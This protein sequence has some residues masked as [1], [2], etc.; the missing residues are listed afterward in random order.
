[1]SINVITLEGNNKTPF[2]EF[3]FEKGSVTISGRI[4]PENPLEF[5]D[6]L[7]SLLNRSISSEHPLQTV[8]IALDYFNSVSSKGFLLFLRKII[9]N[10]SSVNIN[11]RYQKDDVEIREAGEDYAYILQHPFNFVEISA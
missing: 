1:M 10:R 11:W 2:V 9:T 4:I 6:K 3:D 5:F 8:D 7:D